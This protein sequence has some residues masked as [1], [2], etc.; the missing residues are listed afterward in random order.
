MKKI[1]FFT[2]WM[3]TSWLQ[4]FADDAADAERSTFRWEADGKLHRGD[5][6][7]V[8]TAFQRRDLQD[9]WYFFGMAASSQYGH[10][11][12]QA[13]ED[14]LK[15]TFTESAIEAMNGKIRAHAGSLL[16]Q[17]PG[18]AVL[19]GDQIEAASNAPPGWDPK[20]EHARVHNMLALGRLGTP[21]AIQQMGRFLQ[22]KRNPQASLHTSSDAG[23]PMP[24]WFHAAYALDDAL[25]KKSPLEGKRPASGI[26]KDDHFKELQQWW[27]SEASL[28]YRQPLPGL[29]PA[30]A[31]ASSIGQQGVLA[32]K[33]DAGGA[34][35]QWFFLVC[36]MAVLLILLLV[37]QSRFRHRQSRFKK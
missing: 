27:Q 29:P 6:S 17:I 36:L 11:R 25:G 35:G 33:D 4:A 22:D 23:V 10:G 13:E 37:L 15:N 34:S 7:P 1:L 12:T 28:A 2:A 24:N 3:L 8:D 20:N 30:L 32:T 18:H 14:Q 9:L 21:E 31:S 19:L 16:A 26:L 5:L